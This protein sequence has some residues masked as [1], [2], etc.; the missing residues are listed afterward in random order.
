[1]A[2]LAWAAVLA[3][4]TVAAGRLLT[5]DPGARGLEF[6]PDMVRTPAVRSFA[7]S[8]ALPGGTSMQP[9]VEGVVVRGSNPFEYG[10]GTE[11]AARAGRELVNP[12]AATDAAALARGERIF[13]INC[14]V[15]HGKDGETKPP[16]VLRGVVAPP[17][18]LAAR[19]TALKDGEMFHILTRGQGKMPSYASMV[20]LEDRWKAILHV[21]RLQQR[22][23][24][25]R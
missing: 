16:A 18:L 6:A 15:C 13:E 22:G 4:A 21:R 5:F 10:F 3:V 8:A 20:A 2:W 19:A 14:A 12:F 17:S 7:A 1:M 9:L 23:T 11:E 25:T 24:A